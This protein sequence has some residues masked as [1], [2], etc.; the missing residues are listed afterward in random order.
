MR[1]SRESCIALGVQFNFS[2]TWA[3]DSD[4]VHYLSDRNSLLGLVPTDQP[5]RT[6]WSANLM[7]VIEGFA[8]LLH[9]AGI[10]LG[11]NCSVGKAKGRNWQQY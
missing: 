11:I 10:E 9:H 1:A 6:P 7:A 3:A 8:V 2:N 4:F 5:E